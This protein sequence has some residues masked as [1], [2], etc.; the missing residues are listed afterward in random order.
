MEH[1]LLTLIVLVATAGIASQWV[2][3]RLGLPAIVVLLT[4][5]FLLGPATGVLQP[6]ENFGALLRPAISAAVA[7]IVLEGGL[8]LNFA[9]IRSAGQGILR[10]ILIGVPL[11]W[12][13][14]AAAAHYVGG[15]SW[16]IA[17][18]LGAMLVITGPT[19]IQPLLRQAKLA[20]RP[21]AFLKW[22]GV[23][24]DAIGAVLAVLVL[25]FLLAL[26]QREDVETTALSALANLALGF[27]TG[28]GLGLAAAFLTRLLFLR[29]YAPEFLKAPIVLAAA[30]LIYALAHSVQPESGLIAVAVFGVGLANMNLP[31][32]E[33]LRRFKESLTVFLVSGL[34]IVVTANLP[35][36]VF[37]RLGWRHLAFVGAVLLVVRPAAMWLATT[38]TD[39]SWRE[40]LFVA[41]IAP[42][43]IVVA[44]LAGLATAQLA[45]P[46]YP[47]AVLVL[48]L[49][50]AIIGATVVLHG[51]LMRPLAQALGLAAPQRP[52]LM[53]VGC[54]PWTAALA[55]ALT[56]LGTPVLISDRSPEALRIAQDEGLTTHSGHILAPTDDEPEALKD[57]EFLLAATPNT[58][59]NA[60]V[61]VRFAPNLGQ[62]HVYQTAVAEPTGALV[63]DRKWRGKV[64]I[65]GDMPLERL[66]ERHAQGWRFAVEDLDHDGS[67]KKA[68]R[69]DPDR[70]LPVALVQS[71]GALLFASPDTELPLRVGGKLVVFRA[72]DA[73]PAAGTGGGATGAAAAPAT[74]TASPGLEPGPVDGP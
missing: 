7:I 10:M 24:N 62:Q 57:I 33:E 66:L 69:T 6:Q 12:L 13:L 30:L 55:R 65:D 40:R 35:Q 20:R 4:V 61:C 49:V 63:V 37:D 42:R 73:G 27:V 9:E 45:G 28:S 48:P 52:G 56:S 23:L 25:E 31:E 3:W 39:M 19:V 36:T 70:R 18:L 22:E 71:D 26:A 72:P 74:G 67:G 43:G 68:F 34:F 54:N 21:A 1:H 32:I 2:A 60:L 11:G 50:F 51:L 15:L 8:S 17:I 58:A 64:L 44:A 53:V 59:F 38:A 14:G 46:D 5:G 47:D 16:S 29:P 41:F